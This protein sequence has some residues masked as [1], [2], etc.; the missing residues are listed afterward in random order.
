MS[1]IPFPARDNG[2]SS[3]SLRYGWL[4]DEQESARTD[5]PVCR[6]EESAAS[7]GQVML[8]NADERFSGME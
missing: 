3:D 2:V 1:A 8:T 4:S 6:I 5:D 7:H